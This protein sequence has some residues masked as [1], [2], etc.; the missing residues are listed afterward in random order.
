M[1]WEQG[2]FTVMAIAPGVPAGRDLI[3]TSVT[4][5]HTTDQLDGFLAAL[6]TGL[7]KIGAIR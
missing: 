1:L 5:L 4:A 3:R 6:R 7:K 2:Y